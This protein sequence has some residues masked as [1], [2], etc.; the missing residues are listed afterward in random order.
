MSHLA[1]SFRCQ[2]PTTPGVTATPDPL[3]GSSYKAG[4]TV[5]VTCPLGQ[6]IA[7]PAGFFP[8]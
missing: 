4:F 8:E 2:R 1:P 5:T 7:N 6:R 3:F